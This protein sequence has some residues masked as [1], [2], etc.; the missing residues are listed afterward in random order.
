MSIS[1]SSYLPALIRLP[2]SAAVAVER[3]R[4]PIRW[5]EAH[6]IRRPEL[7][8]PAAVVTG[9][10]D[11]IGE[12]GISGVDLHELVRRPGLAFRRRYDVW[13]ADAYQSPV[14]RLDLLTRGARGHAEKFVE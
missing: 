13:V 10:L 12:R 9:A 8:L 1:F 2:R 3:S 5:G 6:P 11:G 4:S 14:R 7:L